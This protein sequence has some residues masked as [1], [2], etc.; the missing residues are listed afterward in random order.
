MLL[1]G[2]RNDY[3]QRDSGARDRYVERSGTNRVELGWKVPYDDSVGLKAFREPW[4]RHDEACVVHGRRRFGGDI[5]D[6][7]GRGVCTCRD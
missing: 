6:P 5:N 1:V 4:A 3:V 7:H 2:T